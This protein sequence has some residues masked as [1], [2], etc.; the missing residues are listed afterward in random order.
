M[1]I[2]QV[3]KRQIYISFFDEGLVRFEFKNL[4]EKY[5]P[6]RPRVVH[7]SIDKIKSICNNYAALLFNNNINRFERI[8]LLL[9]LEGEFDDQLL[10][11]E[12]E[13]ENEELQRQILFR[14]LVST[15]NAKSTS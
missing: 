8:A 10:L 1:R 13:R 5:V 7:V 3:M 4:E 15:P 12:K 6:S 14:I 9:D 11:T 2:G